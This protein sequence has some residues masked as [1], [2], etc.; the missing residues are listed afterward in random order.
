ML[1]GLDDGITQT[2]ARRIAHVGMNEPTAQPAFE[3]HANV[4]EPVES[5]LRTRG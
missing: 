2:V 5:E 3:L 1:T 4:L